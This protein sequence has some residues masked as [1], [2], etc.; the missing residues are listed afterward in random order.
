[1]TTWNFIYGWQTMD[2]PIRPA[3][4]IIFV[5]LTSP[6]AGSAAEN[7]QSSDTFDAPSLELLEFL[8]SFETDAGE[9]ISPGELMQPNFEQL[10]ESVENTPIRA[11]GASNNRGNSSQSNDP[12]DGD[13]V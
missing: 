5:L 10:L 1:M 7:P 8:G 4:L 12:E 11:T 2:Y 9:W 3:S 6:P 13:E